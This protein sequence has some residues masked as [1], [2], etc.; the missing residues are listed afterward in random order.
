M[1]PTRLQRTHRN[2]NPN[3]N[4]NRNS[5]PS[6]IRKPSQ[7]FVCL[8]LYL[9]NWLPLCL[10]IVSDVVVFIEVAAA[11][12]A[13]AVAACCRCCSLLLLLL[14]SLLSSLLGQHLTLIRP[15][16]VRLSLPCIICS[17]AELP[18]YA[19]VFLLRSP[20]NWLP[21]KYVSEH[22]YLA[23]GSDKRY[24]RALHCTAYLHVCMRI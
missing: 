5:I 3:P 1:Q 12:V 4:C 9:S 2:P 23:L 21:S 15:L 24:M 6:P 11:D 20:F 22:I 10:A 14:S 7:S 17:W 8:A 18:L 16:F 13:A 19:N